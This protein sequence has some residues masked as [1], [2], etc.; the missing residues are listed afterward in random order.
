MSGWVVVADPSDDVFDALRENHSLLRD[1]E[2]RELALIAQACDETCVDQTAAGFATERLIVGGA[3]GTACI[4]EFLSMELGG[5]LGVDPVEA[6]ILIRDV[7]N[8][9]DRH[10]ELWAHT[11]AGKLT[12]KEAL[13]VAQRCASAG[14]SAEAAR[15][16]DHQ[17]ALTLAALPWARVQ[18]SLAGLIVK[19]D[20]ALAAQRAEQRRKER[21]VYI[22]GHT[23]G[24]SVLFGRLDTEDALALD[25][26]ISE[27]AN[28]L[29][30]AGST[31]LI[32]QR[33]ATALGILADPQAAL[34]LLAGFGDGKPTNRKAT[35]VVHIAADQ[36]YPE[37][38]E[39]L[40]GTPD[41]V[42][43]AWLQAGPSSGW[44]QP[45]PAIVGRPPA[46]ELQAASPS[47]G[48]PPNGLPSGER[49]ICDS[50]MTPH[51]LVIDGP[52]AEDGLTGPE[53]PTAGDVP[54]SGNPPDSRS[55]ASIETPDAPIVTV[56]DAALDQAV[57]AV[58]IEGG[59]ARIEGVG[60]LDLQTLRRFL[61]H[62]QVT[63]KPVV[64]L[65]TIPPVD[66]YEVPVRLRQHVLARNPVEAF[67]FS[68][69]PANNCDL[70]HTVPYD[71][72]AHDGAEQTRADNLGP[73]SRRVHRAKTARLWQVEQWQP[74]WYTWTS[75]HGFQYEVGP[76]GTT[77]L[78]R[79]EP[80][81]DYDDYDEHAA[82][83]DT[84][85]GDHEH[86]H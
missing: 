61:G 86:Q 42:L 20:A 56:K 81:D 33:R 67:P 74:G 40:R 18:R 8:L 50:W 3:D 68:A 5:L 21:H 24:A 46:T 34:D 12:P 70:D 45:G 10:P 31:E 73:L 15:W 28:A 79:P 66:H 76:Y 47:T 57:P 25:Q 38:Y 17:L 82:H 37:P 59:V 72:Q 29:A 22:G 69:R 44:L 26:T 48:G 32:D 11:H 19:A 36:V 85:D 41:P 49:S 71:W 51:S 43:T 77:T 14:L 27:V 30:A 64:D 78:G 75:P 2:L 83:E 63:V 80:R 65:N 1:A 35:L 9:R 4:G 62:T 16:V 58:L 39:D 7:L 55:S 84:R 52:G 53:P 23:D 13:K 6:S 60:P 54:T